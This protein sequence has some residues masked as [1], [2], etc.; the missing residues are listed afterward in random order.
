MKRLRIDEVAAE[1]DVSVRTV[2][3]WIQKGALESIKIRGTRRISTDALEERAIDKGP[4]KKRLRETDEP[5]R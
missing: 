1:F 5:R 4:E 2:R 3:R